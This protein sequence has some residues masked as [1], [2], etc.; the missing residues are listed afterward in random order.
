MPGI[1]STFVLDSWISSMHDKHPTTVPPLQTLAIVLN[2][3]DTS[4]ISRTWLRSPENVQ[5]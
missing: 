4:S 2:A 3:I 1:E 5:E